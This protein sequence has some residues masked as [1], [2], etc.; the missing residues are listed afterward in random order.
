MN[1]KIFSKMSRYLHKT[2]PIR[3]RIGLQLL[4]V[5]SKNANPTFSGLKYHR[6]LLNLLIMNLEI[7]GSTFLKATIFFNKI[8]T[9]HYILERVNNIKSCSR[10]RYLPISENFHNSLH[11]LSFVEFP[12]IIL[13][14]RKLIL[15]EILRKA[16]WKDFSLMDYWPR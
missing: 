7:S 14:K 9:L 5:S 11:R 4:N 3:L 16:L 8:N 13:W 1:L 6:W 2:L 12:D 15:T 10:G